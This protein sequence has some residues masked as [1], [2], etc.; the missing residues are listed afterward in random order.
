MSRFLKEFLLAPCA[1][2]VQSYV[3]LMRIVR[4]PPVIGAVSKKYPAMEKEKLRRSLFA[5]V[6]DTLDLPPLRGWIVVL[7]SDPCH[8]CLMILLC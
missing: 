1:D 6:C 2:D 4:T 3:N 7:L 8:L 5:D